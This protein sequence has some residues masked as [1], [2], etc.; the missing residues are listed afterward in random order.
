M[1]YEDNEASIDLVKNPAAGKRTRHIAI[2]FHHIQDEYAK[3]IINIQH[4]NTF[5]QK[6]D[7][8]TKAMSRHDI[9]RFCKDFMEDA[10]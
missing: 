8:M 4:I 1:I 10:K 7:M 6:A 5:N 2:R 3:G 9:N